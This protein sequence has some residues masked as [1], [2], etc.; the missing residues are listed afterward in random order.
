MTAPKRKRS[1]TNQWRFPRDIAKFNR[2]L[3]EM[4][5]Q[6]QRTVWLRPRATPDPPSSFKEQVLAYANAKLAFQKLTGAGLD[7]DLLWRH[8][9]GLAWLRNAASNDK[10]LW[11]ALP[12]LPAHTLRRF[13]D[14][15][16]SMA[17]AIEQVDAGMRANKAYGLTVQFLPLFLGG[18]LPGAEIELSAGGEV[19]REVGTGVRGVPAARARNLLQKQAELPKLAGLPNLLRL[20]ADYVEVVSKLTAHHA[21]RGAATFRA[22]M[23]LEL[24]EAVKAVTGK[25]LLS[26]TATLLE[27]AYFAVGINETVDPRN[28]KMQ[29][30]RR[31]SRKK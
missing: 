24:I 9:W 10:S 11:Y 8:L 27:A 23:P 26:A 19:F 31:V 1:Q 17:A 18:A 7:E 14:Q 16:R 4:G 30:R 12:G 20:Y 22:M 13:P 29:Y 5:D 6:S 28:L 2:C 25:P 21:P 3:D 15:V